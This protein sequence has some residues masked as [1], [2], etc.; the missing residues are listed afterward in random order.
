VI[1]LPVARSGTLALG[2]LLAAVLVGEVQQADSRFLIAS[3]RRR[4]PE[5]RE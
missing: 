2:I 5:L 3:V 1:A 4:R